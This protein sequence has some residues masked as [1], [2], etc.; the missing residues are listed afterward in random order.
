[1]KIQFK[2]NCVV[3]HIADED[4]NSTLK[5]E[6]IVNKSY[7]KNEFSLNDHTIDNYSNVSLI[8]H[9]NNILMET[10]KVISQSSDSATYSSKIYEYIKIFAKPFDL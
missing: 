7:L 4:F 6:F 10:E 3:F 2:P 1:M 5:S 9:H 8:D